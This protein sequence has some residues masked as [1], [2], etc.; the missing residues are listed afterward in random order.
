MEVHATN[1]ITQNHQDEELH[2]RECIIVCVKAKFV[3]TV[4]TRSGHP[5]GEFIPT[6]QRKI[7]SLIVASFA[8]QPQVRSWTDTANPKHY[9]YGDLR[10]QGGQVYD[11]T[12]ILKSLLFAGNFENILTVIGE[13][14]GIDILN[15]TPLDTATMEKSGH[16]VVYKGQT[17]PVLYASMKA[18][19][20]QG[21]PQFH[22][23]DE[24]TAHHDM[25]R[26][27]IKQRNEIAAA[28]EAYAEVA[29][30]AGSDSDETR[31]VVQELLAAAARA[32]GET[33][34]RQILFRFEALQASGATQVSALLA[35]RTHLE[36]DQQAIE[37]DDEIERQKEYGKGELLVIDTYNEEL[38]KSYPYEREKPK[39]FVPFK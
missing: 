38:K 16:A 27:R 26:D 3:D 30:G 9:F 39:G 29:E 5:I 4:R 6:W 19:T 37:L 21:S 20:L 8:P 31:A 1:S 28:A 17:V 12:R 23:F 7:A 14:L 24:S 34:L 18:N 15:R 32:Q 36:R 11:Y 35:A 25:D 22:A 10:G 13:Q 33:E 2:F